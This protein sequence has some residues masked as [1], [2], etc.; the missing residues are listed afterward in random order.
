MN[1]CE[2]AA[3]IMAA[4]V[5]SLLGPWQAEALVISRTTSTNL[6]TQICQAGQYYDSATNSCKTIVAQG[7]SQTQSAIEERLLWIWNAS[8]QKWDL[9]LVLNEFVAGSSTVTTYAY[10][11]YSV[12]GTESNP[13]ALP[14]PTALPDNPYVIQLEGFA[15]T[16]APLDFTSYYNLPLWNRIP[17]L[18]AST[19]V[20]EPS[21][22]HLLGVGLAGLA[23]MAFWRKMRARPQ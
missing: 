15:V 22:I 12:T 18:N 13:P 1:S 4:L 21:T 19:P 8:S 16:P 6:I 7:T 9:T 11:L 17:V 14:A 5:V 20:P 2:K 23:G 10:S 3:V